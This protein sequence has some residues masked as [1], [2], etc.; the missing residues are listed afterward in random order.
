M[1]T[2]MQRF[3]LSDMA[4]AA[5]KESKNFLEAL[6]WN[7]VTGPMKFDDSESKDIKQVDN[8]ATGMIYVT[9]LDK[10]ADKEI[11]L[12][13]EGAAKLLKMIKEASGISVVDAERLYSVYQ[14]L[15]GEE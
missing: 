11:E 6:N 9:G 12:S 8:P 5:S 7:K 15:G 3:K 10:V 13:I 14:Q 2:P 4:T 1:M